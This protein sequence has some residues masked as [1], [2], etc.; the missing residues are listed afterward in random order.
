MT[1]V[2][3]RRPPV[4]RASLVGTGASAAVV[5]RYQR[6][7]IPTYRRDELVIARGR[8]SYVWDPEGRRYLDFFPGW[9]VGGLGHCHPAVTAALNRQAR[10]LVHVA[11]NYYHEQQALLAEQ[12]IKRSFP[13]K[14]FFANSGAEVVEAAIKLARRFGHPQRHEIIAMTHSFHGRTMGA[15]AATGQPKY[16]QGFQPLVP[17]FRHVPFN[18]LDAVRSV[19]SERTVAILVEPIQGEGGVHVATPEFLKGLRT[20]CNARNLVLIFDEVQTGMG[21]TGTLFAFQQSGVVPD[22]MTLAKSLGNGLSI[23]ALVAGERFAD[24][25]QPGTHASTF[26]GGAVVCASA[27][28]VLDVIQREHLVNRAARMGRY[29]QQRLERLAARYPALIREVRGRGLMVGMELSTGGAEIVKACRRRGLLINCTQE[30]VLRMLP[31]L[32]VTEREIDRAVT[33]LDEVLASWSISSR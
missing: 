4:R 24:V 23:G 1:T 12:L 27:L 19:L 17:G 9:G 30:T 3:T 13:G 22:V 29:L 26:G 32:I 7:V 11:N 8:G 14:V 21:R 16:H 2:A 20:I 15:V 18:N 5:R 10:R 31:A 6:Y 33:I 25:L 28:A